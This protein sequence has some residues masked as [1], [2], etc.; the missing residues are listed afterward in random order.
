MKSMSGRD[1]PLASIKKGHHAIVNRFIGGKRVKN[2]LLTLGF[3]MGAEVIVQQNSGFGPVV[4]MVRGSRIALGRGEANK[5]I[6]K[7]I[8]SE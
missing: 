1:Q 3:T 2:R 7:E 5:V 8:H 4:V 6:V